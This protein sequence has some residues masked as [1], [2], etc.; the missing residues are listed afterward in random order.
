MRSGLN[1][2]NRT[3]V[4]QDFGTRK[5]RLNLMRLGPRRSDENLVQFF[6]FWKWHLDFE[7]KSI[8]LS[9]WKRICSIHLERILGG[10]YNE[11]LFQCVGFPT[12]CHFALLHRFQQGG[13]SLGC[14][15]VHFVCQ[16]NLGEDGTRLKFERLTSFFV[17]HHDSCSGDICRHQI[18]GELDSRIIEIET[19][20]QSSNKKRFAQS[21]NSL[22]QTMPT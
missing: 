13:L 16:Y 8:Q 20:A 9:L 7:Q 3:S 2:T 17:L 15:P 18:G 10:Q 21:W 6:T 19:I 22:K 5:N 14:R 4:F 11:G 12:G 1:H